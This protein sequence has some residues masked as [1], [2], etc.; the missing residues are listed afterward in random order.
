MNTININD[1]TIVAD[2]SN[3]YGINQRYGTTNIRLKTTFSALKRR[4]LKILPFP[5][6]S[7]LDLRHS[8]SASRMLASA[9]LEDRMKFFI[10]LDRLFDRLGMK[11]ADYYFRNFCSY[12]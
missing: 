8:F 5:L 6:D 9:N 10:W 2:S 7:G 4:N 1:S 11:L 12:K 3:S